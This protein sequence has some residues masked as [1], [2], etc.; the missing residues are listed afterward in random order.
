MKSFTSTLDNAVPHLLYDLSIPLPERRKKAKEFKSLK[1]VGNFLGRPY[2]QLYPLRK[3]GCRIMGKD[4]K[5]YALRIKK[6]S[7]DSEK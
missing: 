1:D 7:Q 4:G 3:P 2:N 5:E 6:I